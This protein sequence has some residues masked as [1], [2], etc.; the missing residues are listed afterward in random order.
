MILLKVSFCHFFFNLVDLVNVAFTFNATAPKSQVTTD[1]G[2]VSDVV[3]ANTFT[4][5]IGFSDT[6]HNWR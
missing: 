1:I 4:I 3:D 2:I 6:C 5:I